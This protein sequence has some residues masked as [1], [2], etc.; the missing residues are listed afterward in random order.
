MPDKDA[1]AM[2]A[3]VRK[4]RELAGLSQSELGDRLDVSYQQVQKYERGMNR[5][6]VDTLLRLAKALDQP[7]SVFL[8]PGSGSGVDSDQ[9]FE[10]PLDYSPL[11][12]EERDMLKA[13]RELGDD[14]IRAAF[15]ITLKA[16]ASRK[17]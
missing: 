5:M 10:A 6:S 12:R 16:V 15:L 11:T 2:G 4:Y 9:V 13:F 3:K 7:L 14:K 8:P 1:K 17:H